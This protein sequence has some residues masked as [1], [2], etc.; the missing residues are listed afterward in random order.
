MEVNIMATQKIPVASYLRFSSDN[1]ND[2]SIQYQKE[3]ILAYA[4]KHD[5]EIVDTYIDEGY[6]ATTSNRPA[7]QEMIA[8]AQKKHRWKKV[9]I[10]DFSRFARNKSDAAYYTDLLNDLD[11]ELISITQE[12]GNSPEGALLVGLMHLINE[13][14]SKNNAK[15]THA[16]MK[17]KAEQG[18]HCGGKPPLGYDLDENNFLIINEYEAQIVREIFDMYLLNYSYSRMAE[19][20]NEKG[21]RTKKDKPFNKHS[22]SSI[23]SQKKYVGTFSWNNQ[24]AKNSK[25]KHNSHALKPEEERVYKENGCPQI[26]SKEQFEKVQEKMAS[27]QNGSASSKCRHHYMLGSLKILK[28][29]ECGSLMIGTTRSSHGDKYTTYYCPNHKRGE[30]SMKEIKTEFVD[31]FVAR[32]IA[33]NYLKDA[34]LAQIS[35]ELKK[36]KSTKKLEAKLRG[37]RTSQANILKSLCKESNE[38]LRLKLKSLSQEESELKEKIEQSKLCVIDI[39]SDNK[40][41]V[42]R[43]LVKYLIESDDVAVKQLILSN[44]TEILVGSDDISVSLHNI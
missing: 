15:H 32:V 38:A 20:L 42:Y 3:N 19:I 5:Y 35:A 8:D 23:L 6:S 9:L 34:N 33:S 31:N 26:I 11:I 28:C 24:R 1:Q 13:F 22:F 14:Y 40:K 4:Y 21:Y 29:A 37:I 30:C 17:A 41:S 16:G 39:N 7:F 27:N 25:G 2:N 18:K 36:N 12:F 44:V 43:Q 10:Y